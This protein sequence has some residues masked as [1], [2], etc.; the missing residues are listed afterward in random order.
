[1]MHIVPIYLP[2]VHIRMTPHVHL[3]RLSALLQGL[4]PRVVLCQTPASHAPGAADPPQHGVCPPADG[5][6]RGLDLHILCGPAATQGGA[7]ATLRDLSLLVCPA[8]ERAQWAALQ[9]QGWRPW[10]SFSVVFDGPVGPLLL[11]EL[12]RA[13]HIALHTADTSLAQIVQLMASEMQAT[14]CGQPLLMDRA[15]D[16][17]LIGLLR[18]WVMHPLNPVGLFGGL[19]DPRLARAL[20]AMHSHPAQPWTLDLLA[21]EAGMSRTAFATQFKQVTGVSAGKYLEGL[22]LAMAQR[23]V[24]TGQGLKRVAQETGYA[25]AATLSRAMGR[26]DA[27]Q[28]CPA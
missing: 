17:L 24:A 19:A 5:G 20:V 28:A 22:R 27:R 18:H 23:L 21:V 14:R 3:D 6:G 8:G 15:G 13:E 12:H 11:R 10:V 4:S 1:M 25:S 2:F 7:A 16:I 26:A 9:G